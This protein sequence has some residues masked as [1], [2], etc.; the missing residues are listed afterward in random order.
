[1]EGYGF[2][3]AGQKVPKKPDPP[4]NATDAAAA[5]ATANATVAGNE[6]A[7]A[8]TTTKKSG[9]GARRLMM[10]GALVGVVREALE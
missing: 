9:G 8:A 1:M 4:A 10:P 5:N 6:T 7:T 2:P 3:A